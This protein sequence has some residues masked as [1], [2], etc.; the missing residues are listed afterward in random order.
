MADNLAGLIKRL[1]LAVNTMEKII[2]TG[3]PIIEERKAENI[4][5]PSHPT[6]DAIP[7]IVMQY[8]SLILVKFSTINESAAKIDPQIVALVLYI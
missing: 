7:P 3:T 8:E 6:V 5:I 4:A 1:E 2:G